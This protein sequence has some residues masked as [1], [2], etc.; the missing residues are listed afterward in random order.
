MYRIIL[1]KRVVAEDIPLL[2]K[3]ARSLIQKAIDTRLVSA[4]QHYG[5]PLRHSLSG[6]RRLGVADYR[7]I[8]R[9]DERDKIVYIV[10]IGLRRDIY[11]H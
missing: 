8:Y 10:A 9:I 11:E 4:P 6:H 7:I 2:P 1:E 5:K 3:S